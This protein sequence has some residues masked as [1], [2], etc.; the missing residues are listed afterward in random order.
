MTCDSGSVRACHLRA[1]AHANG[2]QTWAARSERA[3]A[4]AESGARPRSQPPPANEACVEKACAMK[5]MRQATGRNE[6]PRASDGAER[7]EPEAAAEAE[8]AMEWNG[9]KW[10]GTERNGTEREGRGSHSHAL[11]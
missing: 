7:T 4:W 6:R 9:M 5:P 8:S 10:N 1:H 11:N 2:S 3:S